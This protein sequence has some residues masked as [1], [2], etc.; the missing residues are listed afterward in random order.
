MVLPDIKLLDVRIVRYSDGKK[1]DMCYVDVETQEIA[2]KC[3]KINNYNLKGKAIF[4]QI[5]KPPKEG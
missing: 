2:E 5:S 1:K 3:L 4:V